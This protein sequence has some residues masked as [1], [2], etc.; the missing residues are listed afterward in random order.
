MG[1]TR[2]AVAAPDETALLVGR[3]AALLATGA[4]LAE[5]L[6][7]VVD[8]LGLTSAVL[9]DGRDDGGLLAVAGEV[10][11]AVPAMR[12]EAA[13]GLD[14]AVGGDGAVL[15]VA[16]ARPTQLPLL[17][18]A[19]AV[20][21]L[22]LAAR[23]AAVPPDEDDADRVADAL[24]D[25]LHDGPVQVLVAARYACDAAVRGGDPAAARDAVQEAVVALRR[26]MWHLRPRGAA[27]LPAALAA[28]ADRRAEAGEPPL[29]LVVDADAAGRLSPPARALA[30]RL[31]QAA[32]PDRV[33][34]AATA[35]AADV[36]LDLDG[37]VVLDGPDRWLRRLRALGGDL[38]PAPGRL[39]VLLPAAVLPPH[40]RT[41]DSKACS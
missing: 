20:L 26:T 18:G 35:A 8:G 30:Y 5:A 31:V 3:V 28:L 27:D 37:D 13:A 21:G 2:P 11:H 22:A 34:L 40:P 29:A 24:A 4:P 25:A 15:T 10:V 23:A 32:R 41:A 19:C 16:G 17:R 1:P 6:A 38:V 39:R 12:P 9:R 36:R 14:L 7:V 33:V